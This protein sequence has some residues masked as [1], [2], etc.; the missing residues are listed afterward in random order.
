MLPP[1]AKRGLKYFEYLGVPV[2]RE[3]VET[4]VVCYCSPAY[5]DHEFKTTD[6]RR[7]LSSFSCQQTDTKLS[8]LATSK[9]ITD[10]KWLPMANIWMGSRRGASTTSHIEL[11]IVDKSNNGF[12]PTPPHPSTLKPTTLLKPMP[13]TRLNQKDYE[14]SALLHEI[15]RPLEDLGLVAD[16]TAPGVNVWQGWVRV[17]KKGDQSWESRKERLDGVRALDGDFCLTKI[18][19]VTSHLPSLLLGCG[20]TIDPVFIVQ[21]RS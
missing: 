20:V 7:N 3:N 5:L 10:T 19:Y 9:Q 16:A 6:L 12:V 1:K 18:T 2:P 13:I 17:P 8:S 21:V 15:V 14:K 4:I 11:L